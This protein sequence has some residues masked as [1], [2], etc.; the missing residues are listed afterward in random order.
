M[1]FAFGGS[2]LAALILDEGIASYTRKALSQPFVC[3]SAALLSF[4]RLLAYCINSAEVASRAGFA[5]PITCCMESNGHLIACMQVDLPDDSSEISCLP[6]REDAA[7][8]LAWQHLE[9]G[10]RFGIIPCVCSSWY[11]LSLPTFTSVQI[12][13]GR[14]DSVQRFAVWLS[15]HGSILQHL[16][17]EFPQ[18]WW[19]QL[20]QYDDPLG[21]QLATAVQHCSSLRSL[22]LEDWGYAMIP[23]DL[24][25]LEQ[26]TSLELGG[27]LDDVEYARFGRWTLTRLPSQLQAL[28][29]CMDDMGT[30]YDK[31]DVQ[32]LLARLPALTHLDLLQTGIRASHLASCPNL[33]RLQELKLDYDLKF[34]S[35]EAL[36]EVPCTFLHWSGYEGGRG[37]PGVCGMVCA[38]AGEEMP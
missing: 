27:W 34:D 6:S 9:Q 14:N 20:F 3:V 17:L 35:L 24:R 36:G 29:L 30:S 28:N 12:G 33:P 37:D 31:Y 23:V 25:H 22:K 32:Q 18:G 7:L 11:H 21:S 26:L 4:V 38:A 2:G 15:R 5:L 13:L 19:P 8:L 10:H 1:Q 16:S